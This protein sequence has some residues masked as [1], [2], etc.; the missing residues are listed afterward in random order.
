MRPPRRG[1][2]RLT[3]VGCRIWC[4][5]RQVGALRQGVH[6][7]GGAADSRRQLPVRKRRDR[8]WIGDSRLVPRSGL[9]PSSGA[10][11]LQTGMSDRPIPT[12]WSD[13]AKAHK[14]TCRLQRRRSRA[15]SGRHRLHPDHHPHRLLCSAWYGRCFICGADVNPDLEQ[16][17]FAVVQLHRPVRST[18]V[19]PLVPLQ[20]QTTEDPAGVP[21]HR[22]GRGPADPDGVTDERRP[23][24]TGR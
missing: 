10:G 21:M 18:S 3:A 13:R 24:I 12:R 7:V 22:A 6:P 2:G 5:H 17:I 19:K 16:A 15:R 11:D 8:L 4:G 1:W 20:R 9:S 23:M 14:R